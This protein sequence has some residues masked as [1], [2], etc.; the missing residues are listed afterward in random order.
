M[1]ESAVRAKA[2]IC[3]PRSELKAAREAA[4]TSAGVGRRA[5]GCF[6]AR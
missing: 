6:R 3:I 5:S 4:E 2:K 1:R